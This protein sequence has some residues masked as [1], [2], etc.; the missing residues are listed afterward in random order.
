MTLR[1]VLEEVESLRG[2]SQTSSEEAN[3]RLDGLKQRIIDGETTGDPITDF[4]IVAHNTFSPEAEQP[5]RNLA[6]MLKD[7]EGEQVLVVSEEIES[8]YQSGCFG[9]RGGTY[10]ESTFMLGVLNSGVELEIGDGKTDFSLFHGLRLRIGNENLHGPRVI[11]PTE[12]YVAKSQ[13]GGDSGWELVE[14][15]I[16]ISSFVFSCFNAKGERTWPEGIMISRRGGLNK[17]HNLLVKVGEDVPNSFRSQ[18]SLYNDDFSYVRALELLGIKDQAPDDFVI[19]YNQEIGEAKGGIVKRLIE[20]LE[21]GGVSR[22]RIESI[23]GVAERGGVVS[24]RGSKTLVENED[25]AFVV[26]FR[27]KENLQR[28][29]REIKGQLE[30]AVK[31]GM[32]DEELVLDGEI[33][34]QSLDAQVLIRTLCTTYE[35]PYD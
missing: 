8:N 32:H 2:Q 35:V 6:E 19:G 33:P 30:S 11:I 21:E 24:E 34:G 12:R 18:R 3:A 28:V 10:V 20:L 31:L 14:G 25:D 17:R 4:A 7:R 15:N 16:Q 27:D 9:D 13:G 22:S 26:S 23:Y 29:C 1:E 5:Y